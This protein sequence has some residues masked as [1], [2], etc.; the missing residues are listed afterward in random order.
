M[1]SSRI[2]VLEVKHTKWL[3]PQTESVD[4]P[5]CSSDVPYSCGFPKE[6]KLRL[7]ASIC[8]VELLNRLLE[9]G[10][11]PDAADE[12]LRSPLHLAASRGKLLILFF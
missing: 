5:S 4:H 12:H 1:F 10:A 9:S 7:A 3:N 8:N 6:R 11:N 2:R